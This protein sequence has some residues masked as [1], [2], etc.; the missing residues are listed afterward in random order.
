MKI[1]KEMDGNKSSKRCSGQ[2]KKRREDGK[3]KTLVLRII[4]S[5]VLVGDGRAKM[6]ILS[7]RVIG[8][9][10]SH[11]FFEIYLCAALRFFLSSSSSSC[12]ATSYIFSHLHRIIVALLPIVERWW[13]RIKNYFIHHYIYIHIYSVII[14]TYTL[15]THDWHSSLFIYLD[16][17]IKTFMKSSRVSLMN[18]QP[19]LGCYS[20]DLS[21][22]IS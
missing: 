6:V 9:W 2:V 12:A 4:L 1:G 13:N 19:F 11:A 15:Q 3:N 16:S 20:K 10:N 8:Q 14:H 22:P 7:T 5:S 18:I 21:F 17:S